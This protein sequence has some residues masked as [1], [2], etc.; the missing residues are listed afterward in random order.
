VTLDVD[1]ALD[2]LEK[3]NILLENELF[4]PPDHTGSPGGLLQLPDH[5]TPVVIGDLHA[6]IENLLKILSEN[7]F[8]QE[9]E[10][11]TGVLVFLGDLVQPDTEPYDEMDSSVF[12]MDILLKLKVRY[13][14]GVF[15][16]RGN[17]DGFSTEVSKDLVP[18]A[19][20]WRKKLE[21]IRGEEY[22]EQMG[23]F[24]D[25]S[26]VVALSEQFVA[27][28]AGPP[29]GKASLKKIINIRSHP[30]LM[31]DLMWNRVRRPGRPSGYTASDV[32]R[33]RKSLKLE[34]QH[35]FL[36]S[37]SPYS[38]KGTL[39]CDVAGIENHHVLYSARPGYVSVFIR[40]NGQMV[41]QVYPAEPMLE[42]IN[43]RAA[44]TSN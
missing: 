10:A 30:D 27:C 15:F 9:L 37:H 19:V 36:V 1:E 14:D 44:G 5:V 41:P 31:H 12:M 6:N 24:Y 21:E 28:H 4:R 26:S 34:K 13:P 39:W 11:G 23:R 35:T 8:M 20:L 17:H 43:K 3:V 18:Q 32:R 33:F 25:L 42:W 16:L 29:L 40:V 38:D 22:R 2:T 7:A